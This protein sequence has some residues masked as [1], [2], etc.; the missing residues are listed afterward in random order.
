[1]L[2]STDNHFALGNE[3]SDSFR[4]GKDYR[5]KRQYDI[6]VASELTISNAD[7]ASSVRTI[8]STLVKP[9]GVLLFVIGK[10]DG[11]NQALRTLKS[12]AVIFNLLD[13]SLL[14]ACSSKL[15]HRC[16]AENILVGVRKHDEA[17]SNNSQHQYPTQV[18]PDALRPRSDQVTNPPR[19]IPDFIQRLWRI[20][21][22]QG[23]NGAKSPSLRSQQRANGKAGIKGNN[24]LLSEK[25]RLI[26]AV[27]EALSTTAM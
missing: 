14:T 10:Y 15:Q 19:N 18:L 27:R 26:E 24:A 5:G 2:I 20:A 21:Y 12:E 6:V 1:M 25:D 17:T 9:G 3:E 4:G 8:L 16:R 22:K 13:I 11:L 23:P 7:M